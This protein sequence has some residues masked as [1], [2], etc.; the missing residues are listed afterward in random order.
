[1]QKHNRDTQRNA[2][3]S[4]AQKRDGTWYDINKD[5]LD[6]TKA[7][8][9]GKLALRKNEVGEFITVPDD[10]GENLLEIVYED[11]EMKKTYTFDEVRANAAI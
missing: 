9:R 2:F 5:P 11:G 1:M 6:K 7:S 10:G 8:K 4:S 3:K